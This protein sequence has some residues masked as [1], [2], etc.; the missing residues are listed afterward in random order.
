MTE[1]RCHH[2]NAL[3]Y[4]AEG[5]VEVEVVCQKCRH[6]NYP[7]RQDPGIGLR[8]KDFQTKAIDHNCHKCQRLLFR[9]IGIGIIETKCKYCNTIS[10][11]DTLLMRTGKQKMQKPETAQDRKFAESVAR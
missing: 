8:G 2:C 7:S 10:A 9:S 3:L 6:I 11:F 1:Y 5:N 4:K